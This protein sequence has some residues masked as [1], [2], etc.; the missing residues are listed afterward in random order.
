[1]KETETNYQGNH[2]EL[3]KIIQEHFLRKNIGTGKLTIK[4]NG[5]WILKKDSKKYKS[6]QD[7]AAKTN[8]SVR[9]YQGLRY[10]IQSNMQLFKWNQEPYGGLENYLNAIDPI[11]LKDIS[12]DILRLKNFGEKTWEELQKLISENLH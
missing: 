12:R 4:R 2:E 3:E 7:F 8:M 10:Y 11:I 5:T 9:L 1:M 6:F